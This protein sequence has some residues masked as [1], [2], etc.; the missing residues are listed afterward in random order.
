MHIC[1]TRCWGYSFLFAARFL[2][3][4]FEHSYFESGIDADVNDDWIRYMQVLALYEETLW[5]LR[6]KVNIIPAN[7]MSRAPATNRKRVSK[8]QVISER[9]REVI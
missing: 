1:S 8:M 3:V 6:L 2:Q 9:K 7:R 5:D 4:L